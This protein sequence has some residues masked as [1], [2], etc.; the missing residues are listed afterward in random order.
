VLYNESK[1]NTL[2]LQHQK[3]QAQSITEKNQED[4]VFR[5]SCAD[6]VLPKQIAF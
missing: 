1:H 2:A 4:H 5:G 6:A 3:S